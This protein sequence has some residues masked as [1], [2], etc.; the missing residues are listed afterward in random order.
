MTQEKNPD[1]L[2]LID[3]LSTNTNVQRIMIPQRNLCLESK[4]KKMLNSV[5][6]EMSRNKKTVDA[7][8]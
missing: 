8:A 4:N 2:L 1:V 5:R 3:V 6:M 7:R